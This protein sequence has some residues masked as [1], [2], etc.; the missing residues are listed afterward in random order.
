M[1]KGEQITAA[2]V[3][4]L[5]GVGGLQAVYDSRILESAQGKS[6]YAVVSETGENATQPGLQRLSPLE[7]TTQFVVAII[8]TGGDSDEIRFDATAISR[9][10]AAQEAVEAKLLTLNQNLGNLIE[11]LNY[12]GAGITARG[13]GE[14]V[15]IVRELRF[16]A[17]WYR[18]LPEEA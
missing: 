17:L 16:D 6:L 12:T 18:D 14:Q 8:A 2:I 3:E 1:T 4:K 10:R 11:R 7:I 9:L 13:E 15:I 5:A